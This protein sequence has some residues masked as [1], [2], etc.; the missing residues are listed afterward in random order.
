MSEGVSKRQQAFR[1]AREVLLALAIVLSPFTD[2]R[3]QV[4]S[5]QILGSSIAFVPVFFI[6]LLELA[7][8][9]ISYKK[10]SWNYIW[11]LYYVILI[12]I[13]GSI[14]SVNGGF[15]F[16]GENV[17]IKGMK[18]A[19]L[20]ILFLVPIS[21][22]Y[23]GRIVRVSFLIAFTIAILGI[24][25][26]DIVGMGGL[27]HYTENIQ[28]RPR[29]FTRESSHLSIVILSLGVSSAYYSRKRSVKILIFILMAASILYSQSKG[30]ILL[31]AGMALVVTMGFFISK[32]ANNFGVVL[33]RW[34]I[35]IGVLTVAS[36]VGLDSIS[37]LLNN[38]SSSTSFTTRSTLL[39]AVGL[40][41]LRYPFG[42]GF[43]GYL[44]ALVQS[45]RDAILILKELD[46]ALISRFGEVLTYV[47][48]ES[49]KF[50]STKTLFLDFAVWFGFPG[51]IVI[52]AFAIR[53]V[54]RL[55]YSRN[56]ILLYGALVIVA[57]LMTYIS[58]IG[59]YSIAALLGVIRTIGNSDAQNIIREM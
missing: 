55:V 53:S 36:I 37:I 8:I 21:Q 32:P 3:L 44:P 18:Q 47:T 30:G 58:G 2:L 41:L 25:V 16:L 34:M 1:M 27:F 29:G 5:L 38:Y 20:L 42:V 33:V 11:I 14:I 12:S 7:E 9:I 35:L 45:I 15:S 19:L 13:V 23:K 26:S 50:I 43:T 40:I 4:T 31:S 57:G 52:S 48:S 22:Q 17:F 28:L 10:I 51:I 24:I 39:V 54:N 56:W 59:L 46:I 49:D 6:L